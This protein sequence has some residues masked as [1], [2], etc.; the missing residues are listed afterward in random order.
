MVA[1]IGLAIALMGGVGVA[2][3]NVLLAW[4]ESFW[5]TERGLYWAAGLRLMLGVVL[6]SSADATGWPNFV[7]AIGALSV[8]GAIVLPIIGRE[9]FG[10]MIEW[11][12]AKPP[13]YLR[14][15]CLAVVALGA[16]LIAAALA[17][18]M[19]RE[20]PTDTR[21]GAAVNDGAGDK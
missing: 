6:L 13:L 15:W 19:P 8:F 21:I 14:V 2:S 20:L 1:V 9:R 10:R 17:E 7:W 12:L 18:P 5:K 11:W 4:V 16:L 3:P